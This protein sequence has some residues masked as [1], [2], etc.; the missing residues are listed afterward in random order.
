[1]LAKS[2]NGRRLEMQPRRASTGDLVVEH[3]PVEALAE[4]AREL[5]AACA[6]LSRDRDQLDV[7]ALHC[8]SLRPWSRAYGMLRTSITH[9]AVAA[10]DWARLY[11][12]RRASDG[13]IV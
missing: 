8:R 6:E 11:P 13:R 4:L 5:A 12:S 10:E 9:A 2:L 1:M 3:G 7:C